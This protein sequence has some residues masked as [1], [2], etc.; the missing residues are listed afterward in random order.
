MSQNPNS[1]RTGASERDVTGVGSKLCIAFYWRKRGQLLFLSQ[2]FPHFVVAVYGIMIFSSTL[3]DVN[4]YVRHLTDDGPFV[5][6]LQ[7]LLY[8]GYLAA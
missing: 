2:F 6:F 5:I 8:S 7:S 4:D 3:F 1:L